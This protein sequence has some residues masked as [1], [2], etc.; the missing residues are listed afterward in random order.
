MIHYAHIQ[1][2]RTS[3]AELVWAINV[4]A[5]FENDPWKFMDVNF[6]G[7]GGG[8]LNP[9][10]LAHIDFFLWNQNS[11]W[12]Q[13]LTISLIETLNVNLSFAA[14]RI[15][16]GNRIIIA[17]HWDGTGSWNH[18]SWKTMICYCNH[19]KTYH[20]LPW[21]K[22][23]TTSAISVSRYAINVQRKGN[24]QKHEWQRQ[25][26]ICPSYKIKYLS[27]G[28]SVYSSKE[29]VSNKKNQH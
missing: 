28:S 15:F 14:T 27:A 13:I 8:A 6:R 25:I 3:M 7:G 23:L 17:R 29:T 1:W 21:E 2:D 5:K 10:L 16:W 22:I 24:N 11:N 26:L 20:C 9:P 12:N 19:G 4:L 18:S